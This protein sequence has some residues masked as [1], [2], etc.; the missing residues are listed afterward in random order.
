MLANA[1]IDSVFLDKNGV[2]GFTTTGK[3]A[4]GNK[5]VGAM[6][7]FRDKQLEALAGFDD[8]INRLNTSNQR[9]LSAQT[10]GIPVDPG[11][12]GRDYFKQTL[13]R[14]SPLAE[15]TR[16]LAQESDQAAVQPRLWSYDFDPETNK[17][18]Y[19]G[20]EGTT[21]AGQFF[22]PTKENLSKLVVAPKE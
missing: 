1:Y 4:L 15:Q 2:L 16:G 17:F 20:A 7:V 6:K 5:L 8:V 3:D 13:S 10:L 18:R 21:F 9:I 12:F 19:K 11:P 22:E 14:V